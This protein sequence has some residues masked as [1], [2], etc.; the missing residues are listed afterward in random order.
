MIWTNKGKVAEI[1]PWLQ[2]TIKSDGRYVMLPEN[3]AEKPL[4]FF[5]FFLFDF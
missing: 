5:F 2:S 4:V 1:S 3:A